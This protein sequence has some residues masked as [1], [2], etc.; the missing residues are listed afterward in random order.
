MRTPGFWIVLLTLVGGAIVPVSPVAAGPEF[1]A[2]ASAF[3][4]ALDERAVALIDAK[5]LGNADRER[6]FRTM[7]VDS[8]DVPMIG[9]FV[10]GRAWRTASDAQKAEFLTLFE[11]MI[12][13]TYSRR[14]TAYRGERAII[15]GTRA[16]NDSAVV[17]STF[18]QANG[19]PLK[20]D[21]RVVKTGGQLKIVDVVIE[22]VSMSLMQQQEFGAVIQRDGG[23]IDGL[24]GTM[25]DRVR[26]QQSQARN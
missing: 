2:E 16:D 21:W 12:V 1:L 13:T 10:L 17:T 7:F 9:R 20:L 15:T 11:D 6:G 8:F 24:L 26:Q 23:R 4:R 3:V 22:G 25:R 14:F 18:T 19:S 5:T